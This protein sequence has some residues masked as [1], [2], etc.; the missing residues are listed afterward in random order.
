MPSLGVGVWLGWENGSRA[1]LVSPVG[2]AETEK[3]FRYPMSSASAARLTS[4]LKV[5][6]V[7]RFGEISYRGE[8]QFV[9]AVHL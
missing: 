3:S 7:F 2:V 6:P 9:Y 1:I 4:L 5:Q 8:T